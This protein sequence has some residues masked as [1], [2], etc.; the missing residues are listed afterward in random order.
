MSINLNCKTC[1]S[2]DQ[3][4]TQSEKQAVEADYE[5]L[6]K[7]TAGS[8]K[9]N[10]S[11]KDIRFASDFSKN[12]GL[13][14]KRR[15]KKKRDNDKKRKAQQARERAAK[16]QAAKNGG[17]RKYI[18]E[19]LNRDIIQQ[20]AMELRAKAET[21]PSTADDKFLDEAL[22]TGHKFDALVYS[23][24]TSDIAEEMDGMFDDIFID[25]DEAVY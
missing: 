17:T 20:K 1:M 16:E 3:P 13:M 11:R 2:L 12:Q 10:F 8:D 25:A 14:R 22:C 6:K 21:T 15:S 9:N 23:T 4:V 24:M 19:M 7:E 18:K 5:S